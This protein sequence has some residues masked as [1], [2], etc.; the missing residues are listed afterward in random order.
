MNPYL[1]QALLEARVADLRYLPARSGRRNAPY[2]CVQAVTTQEQ[3]SHGSIIAP[4]VMA[5]LRWP[6][7]TGR[8]TRGLNL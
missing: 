7:P 3:D 4:R 6:D 5:R 2:A 1:T 8:Q